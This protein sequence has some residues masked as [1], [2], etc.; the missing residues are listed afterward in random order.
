MQMSNLCLFGGTLY[1][2]SP[3]RECRDVLCEHVTRMVMDINEMMMKR[4]M[5]CCNGSMI[6]K[7]KTFECSTIV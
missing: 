1:D 7:F 2:L 5:S 4:M 6:S 3:P